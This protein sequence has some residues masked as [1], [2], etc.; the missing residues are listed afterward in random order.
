MISVRTSVIY[1]SE[2]IKE[3]RLNLVLKFQ[4][5]IPLGKILLLKINGLLPEL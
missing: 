5:Q 2:Y 1:I 4:L 3:F